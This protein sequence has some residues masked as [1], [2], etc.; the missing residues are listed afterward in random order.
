MCGIWLSKGM[1]VETNKKCTFKN[2]VQPWNG[3]RF[4]HAAL[5]DNQC[6]VR[7][8]RMVKARVEMKWTNKRELALTTTNWRRRTSTLLDERERKRNICK[9]LVHCTATHCMTVACV[10]IGQLIKHTNTD[11]ATYTEEDRMLP[12]CNF[13]LAAFNKQPNDFGLTQCNEEL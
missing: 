5:I 9:V 2:G 1:K 10:C 3:T 6:P 12:T 4:P 8:I 7:V 11:T 13:R